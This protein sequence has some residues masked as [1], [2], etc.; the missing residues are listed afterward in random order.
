V[1]LESLNESKQST[2]GRT[3][4]ESR[5]RWHAVVIVAPSSACAEAQACKGKRYLSSE[6]PRP[7]LAKCDAAT[8]GCKYRHFDDRRGEPRRAEETGRNVKRPASNRRMRKGR[9]AL[10]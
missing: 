5:H 4:K 1:L 6:A 8:C 9:R 7:P 3:A 10:D 2:P